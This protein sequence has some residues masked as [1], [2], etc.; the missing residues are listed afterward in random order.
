[1]KKIFLILSAIATLSISSLSFSMHI[2]D[3]IKQG[4]LLEVKNFIS[5]ENINK[6]IKN[7]NN[8]IYYT[9]LGFACE[10]NQLEIVKELLKYEFINI[11]KGSMIDPIGRLLHPT[12]KFAPVLIAQYKGNLDIA[13]LLLK[14]G[15]DTVI[16]NRPDDNPDEEQVF[17]LRLLAK[18]YDEAPDRLK[19]L[20]Q[21]KTNSLNILKNTRGL[22]RFNDC[23]IITQEEK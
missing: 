20:E 17:E 5:A 2:L 23:R 9:L 22:Q 16:V 14:K 6:Y 8:E 7:P 15:A 11:N 13:Q 3:A 19:F 12:L 18:E 1:M 4:N 10:E 21:R